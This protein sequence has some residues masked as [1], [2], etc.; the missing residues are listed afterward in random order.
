[1]EKREVIEIDGMHCSGCAGTVESAL[2]QSDGVSEA[3]VDHESGTAE[4][5]HT[6]T[7]EEVSNI[8]TGAGYRLAGKKQD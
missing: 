6:L 3:S 2:R 4:L 7:R 8:I 5:V 1:M